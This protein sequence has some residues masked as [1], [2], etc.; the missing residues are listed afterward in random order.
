MAK[1]DIVPLYVH[2]Q[3]ST[4]HSDEGI[5]NLPVI[6]PGDSPI[7]A[8]GTTTARPSAERWAEMSNLLDFGAV[9]DGVADDTASVT[10]W[11]AKG[12]ILFAPAGTYKI[13][14][15][16]FTVDTILYGEGDETAF[17]RKTSD[18]L[19]FS[20]FTVPTT[21]D[22]QIWD[23]KVEEDTNTGSAA[24]AVKLIGPSGYVP[25]L[26]SAATITVQPSWNQVKITAENAVENI[27][28]GNWGQFL[29]IGWAGSHFAVIN[30]NGGAGQI[31]LH[32]QADIVAAEHHVGTPAGD[33]LE[34]WSNGGNWF[35]VSRSTV[36]RD[37]MRAV[38]SPAG[39][40][41]DVRYRDGAVLVS[42]SNTI[43]TITSVVPGMRI[44]LVWASGATFSVTSGANIKLWTAFGS[45]TT[46]V[47]YSTLSLIGTTDGKWAETGRSIVTA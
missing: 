42:G 41:L 29:K 36:M 32:N 45:I 23:L 38:A 25:S 6:D 12:G 40:T 8:N 10:V 39:G 30:E 44:T 31:F 19:A 46:A 17:V 21:I 27:L 11:I 7:L 35:E 26:V 16:T 2:S 33:W 15:V 47:E 14:P 37:S 43:T 24:N 4:F 22:V 1:P 20:I 34:L 3:D 13:D 18:P 5:L 9:G 28:G